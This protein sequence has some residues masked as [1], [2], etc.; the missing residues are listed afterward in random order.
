MKKA[1]IVL[2]ILCPYIVS[3]EPDVKPKVTEEEQIVLASLQGLPPELQLSVILQMGDTFKKA[4]TGLKNLRLTSTYWDTLLNT[5]VGDIV[6]T[7][8]KRFNK[9]PMYVSSQLGIGTQR[10]IRI[11]PYGLEVPFSQ[12]LQNW[13][14]AG[15]KL[16]D[17]APSGDFK[18]VEKTLQQGADINYQ[19]RYGQ[20]ALGIA[21]LYSNLEIVKFLLDDKGADINLQTKRGKTALIITIIHSNDTEIAKLLVLAGADINL[22]DK[23]GRTALM[24][25][26]A[27][28]K[29]EVVK[30]LLANKADINLRDKN[31]ETALDYAKK[32]N[33]T[34]VIKIL[35]KNELNRITHLG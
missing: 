4:I 20:T 8:A 15:Q 9:N 22:Q 35:R 26:A 19:D 6:K 14:S 18:Q 23:R 10:K 34:E 31:G 28:G 7:L 25:A 29:Q 16:T 13:K 27:L 21:A 11:E 5:Y 17:A 2:V 30:F 1:F 32:R 12:I 3:M 33:H 24:W